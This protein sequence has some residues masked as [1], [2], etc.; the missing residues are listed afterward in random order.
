MVVIG[1]LYLTKQFLKLFILEEVDA[2]EHLDNPHAGSNYT[3]TSFIP[4]IVRS[5]MNCK[6]FSTPVGIGINRRM[7]A[8][9][10]PLR[11]GE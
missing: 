7:V 11:S 4:T 8:V 5:R 2:I 10:E 6:I 3:R 1:N 9:L